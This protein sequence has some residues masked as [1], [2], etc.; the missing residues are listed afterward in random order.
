MIE[1]IS[2]L[3]PS[4]AETLRSYKR[5]I[6]VIVALLV[7]TRLVVYF[8]KPLLDRVR[9]IVLEDL[10]SEGMRA[11][12]S[13][14]Y[15]QA[16]S[17]FE[18]ALLKTSDQRWRAKF[19]IAKAD[20]YRRDSKFKEALED[21]KLAEQCRA[22][23]PQLQS[24]ID[25]GRGEV[26]YQEKRYEEAISFFARA[27]VYE[28]MNTHLRSV[29]LLK[30]GHSQWCLGRYDEALETY[31]KAESLNSLNPFRQAQIFYHSALAHH[32]K[33]EHEEAL[34][35][36]K[37]AKALKHGNEQLSKNIELTMTSIFSQMQEYSK[38]S[39]EYSQELEATALT[40][41]ERALILFWRGCAH[42]DE[43][44]PALALQDFLKAEQLDWTVHPDVR[45][46]IFWMR[47]IVCAEENKLIEAEGFFHRA[48]DLEPIRNLEQIYYSLACVHIN[49]GKF[50]EA[51]DEFTTASTAYFNDDKAMARILFYRGYAYL[52]TARLEHAILDW[53]A[54]L[55][56]EFANEDLRIQIE[57]R[58][59]QAEEQHSR[60]SKSL[61]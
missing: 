47:G 8:A 1:K 12:Q 51:V 14:D 11:Y 50:H 53:N 10:Y 52:K 32:S 19:L 49:Q 7:L 9:E 4:T 36:L 61:I 15:G 43:N 6:I 16:I 13:G 57:V 54:A 23:D 58:L 17:T 26:H 46:K 42:L 27:E 48:I 33:I 24:T 31:Q 59:R 18:S 20:C 37:R 45:A 38:T 28:G 35:K 56:Y 41:V 29:L 3:M 25:T 34:K 21:F 60:I 30:K 22:D 55:E 2:S 40:P 5:P 44:E 39:R